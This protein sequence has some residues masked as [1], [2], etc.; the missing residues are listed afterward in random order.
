M[1][2]AE[3]ERKEREEQQ[4]VTEEEIILNEK[5]KLRI[6]I[7]RMEKGGV[8]SEASEGKSG[9]THGKDQAP[10]VEQQST[11]EEVLTDYV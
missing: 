9:E 4:K 1:E 3:K 8:A 10:G 7:E 11:E 2:K 5:E 6:E